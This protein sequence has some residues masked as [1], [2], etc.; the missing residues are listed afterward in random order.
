MTQ[1]IYRLGSLAI[2][3][4]GNLVVRPGVRQ[5]VSDRVWEYYLNLGLVMG[6]QESEGFEYSASADS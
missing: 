3:S 2:W 4:F 1:R 6:C 5:V